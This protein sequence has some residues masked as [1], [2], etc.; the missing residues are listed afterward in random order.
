MQSAIRLSPEVTL[1]IGLIG[2]GNISDTH[3][4]AAAAIPGVAVAAVCAPTRAHAESLA[5]R[6]GATAYDALDSF[7]A[8]RPLDIAIV[9]SPSGLHAE[10]GIA[11]ARRG[12]HV[13][14]EK[15]LDVTTERA[16]ALIAAARDAGVTLGVIFQDRLKPD[17]R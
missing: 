16:D 15:P 7:I 2:A 1:H 17:V 11:A 4:R 5:A 14:V 3:A 10:H 13:L 12:I 6:H 8:H 9:G